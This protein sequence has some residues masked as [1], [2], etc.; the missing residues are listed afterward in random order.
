MK[1]KLYC[2]NDFVFN[3]IIE[4]GICQM[5]RRGE[6]INVESFI[7]KEDISVGDIDGVD[8]EIFFVEEITWSKKDGEL[9]VSIEVVPSEFFKN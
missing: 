8:A 6:I 2:E 7:K 3:S 9:F 5:P 4:W 1:V